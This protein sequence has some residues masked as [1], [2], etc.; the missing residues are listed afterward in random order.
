M[1]L[2]EK[3]IEWKKNPVTPGGKVLAYEIIN[4]LSEMF[5]E[6][7][8]DQIHDALKELS[9]YDARKTDLYNEETSLIDNESNEKS[10]NKFLA[11]L[12]NY[13]D[14]KNKQIE[15]LSYLDEEG[16][17]IQ[18]PTDEE[19]AYHQGWQDYNKLGKQ[20]SPYPTSSPLHKFYLDG[21]YFAEKAWS[22]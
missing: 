18:K 4:E 6:D 8:P 11:I 13:M 22:V 10:S 9:I 21:W 20:N 3:I 2:K 19:H 16:N 12:S 15:E 5:W 14:E 1:N 17:M 7:T